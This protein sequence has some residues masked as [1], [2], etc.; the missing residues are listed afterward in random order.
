[1]YIG[2]S[3]MYV[4]KNIHSPTC[5]LVLLDAVVFVGLAYS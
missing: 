4:Y 5:V 3:G 2:M 1:M